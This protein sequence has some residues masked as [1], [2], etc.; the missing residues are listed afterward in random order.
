V[1]ASEQKLTAKRLWPHFQNC[2]YR[3][4]DVLE[5]ISLPGARNATF[6]G[7]AQRPFDTRSA[8][9]VAMDVV[10]SPE[11]D[12]KACRDVGAPIT[13][14]CHQ[15]NLLW[16]NQTE[17]APYEF[18]RIPKNHIEG[19]FREHEKDF[20]PQ[21]IYRAKTLGHFDKSYQRTFV[22]LG[23]MP[24]V[25][26]E[27]GQ[28]IERLVLASVTMLRDSLNWPK[29]VDLKQ[30][31][32]LVRAIFWLLGAKM[33]HDKEVD[34]FV[35][36]NFREV[37]DVFARVSRHYGESADGL[38]GSQAKR[39]ALTTVAANIE[40]SPSLQLATTEALAYVYEN[41]LITKEIRAEFGTHCT[42]SYLVDYIV[43]RLT[44]WIKDMDQN[45]RSVFEP[46]CGHCAFLV[47]AIRLLTSLL[48]R[49]KAQ[50][51]ARKQY[52][53]ER[54]RGYDKD[55]FAIEIARLSLT[56]TDIPNPNGW[57]LKSRDLFESDLLETA[58]AKSTIILS[59]PPFEDFKAV[60][61]AA[62][63]KKF[64]APTHNNKTTEILHRALS[65]MPENGV[66]GV[67]VPLNILHGRD[68][69]SLREMLATKFEFEEV[70][71]FPDRVFNFAKQE[72]A[73][74]L[75]RKKLSKN[76]AKHSL[77]YRRIRVHGME[78]FIKHPYALTSEVK[79]QQSRFS[80]T[81]DWDLRVPDL[82]SVWKAC[83]N[84]PT[85]DQ[86]AEI[87]NGFIHLGQEHPKLPAGTTLVSD[88]K[89]SSSAVKGF[90]RFDHQIQTHGLPKERWVRIDRAVIF[91]PRSGVQTE[92]PQ[93][94]INF[95]PIQSAPWCLKALRDEKGRAVNSR[96]LVIRPEDSALTLE[97]LWA[98]CNSP[99]TN[100]FAYTRSTKREILAG[101]LRKMRVPNLKQADLS[102][103]SLAVKEYFNAVARHE[104]PKFLLR[105]EDALEQEKEELKILHWRVDAEVLRLYA[106]PVESE[107]ELLDYFAGWS[108]AGVPFA[109]DR[110]FPKDFNEPISLAD[111]LAITVDWEATNK[112]RLALIQK[113][114]EK[115][116][117]TEEKGELQRLQNLAGLKR[118]LV[119]A[120]PINELSKIEQDLRRKGLWKGA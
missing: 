113:K 32:W 42:P 109:Q 118:E 3:R 99:F 7:F 53:R 86:F 81:T 50:P 45:Q 57:E 62:Y 47:A 9:F 97:V 92:T 108:R 33:L 20:N 69:K 84:L 27:A 18:R 120:L 105:G 12:A 65:A 31:Q 102:Q 59:N 43:G 1:L 115:T 29:Q 13:F 116:I 117:R 114:S 82:E 72:S 70:C 101:M 106:L 66:F 87:G 15:G 46:A 100:A 25:E 34:G 67:V 48:P 93:V 91:R 21:T 37:D 23:L 30:G 83:S 6:A 98:I 112:H 61:R 40:S 58:A 104:S 16:W 49:D 54:V 107:R 55:D 78:A 5:N 89:F 76:L 17:S 90:V 79:V 26:K 28:A 68:A 111:F 56:L 63:A 8:C 10:T 71:V 11:D 77:F 24:L 96:F 38:V 94:L 22:D 41:T 52:L 4:S 85:F 36:L 19:F 39:E 44:P 80:E 35:R 2:G 75:G 74:L 60:Q 73:V 14:L 119:A 103:L 110:Y 95:A 88:R 51:D 64:R